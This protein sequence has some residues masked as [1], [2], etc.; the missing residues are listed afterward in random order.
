MKKDLQDIKMKHDDAVEQRT[1]L[2]L[3]REDVAVVKHI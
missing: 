2:Q 3:E 1:L